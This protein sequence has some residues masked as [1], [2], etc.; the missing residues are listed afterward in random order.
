MRY[1]LEETD[2][3]PTPLL[4][5]RRGEYRTNILSHFSNIHA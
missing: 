5:F 2:L 4:L 1:E 3:T